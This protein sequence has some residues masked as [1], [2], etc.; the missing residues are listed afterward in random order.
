LDKRFKALNLLKLG[1]RNGKGNRG[2]K[3]SCI[4]TQPGIAALVALLYAVVK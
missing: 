4:F 1:L 2:I 3:S